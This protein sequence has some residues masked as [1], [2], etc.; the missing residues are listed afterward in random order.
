M[1]YIISFFYI[2][3]FFGAFYVVSPGHGVE[4]I[5]FPVLLSPAV[6]YM[7]GVNKV[8][9]YLSLNSGLS[10]RISP[11]INSIAVPFWCVIYMPWVIG[12]DDSLW[13]FYALFIVIDA[14]FGHTMMSYFV[15]HSSKFGVRTD[16]CKDFRIAEN[17]SPVIG[18]SKVIYISW[19]VPLLFKLKL[20]P[21]IHH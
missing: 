12:Y 14:L 2:M 17:N 21:V 1:I 9:Y 20:M 11:Y 8:G 16:G 4:S 3:L 7:Y 13:I 18:V 6:F 10:S 15:L 5:Y 19:L